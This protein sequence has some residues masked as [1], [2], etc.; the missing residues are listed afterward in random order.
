VTTDPPGSMMVVNDIVVVY[1]WPFEVAL[2]E[3]GRLVKGFYEGKKKKNE[4]K[5]KRKERGGHNNNPSGSKDKKKTFEVQKSN[6]GALQCEMYEA[7]IRTSL[8]Q[9]VL[10]QAKAIPIPPAR[11]PSN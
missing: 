2:D 4:K 10:P 8:V 7:T 9:H 3:R 1:T 6:T 11:H 5:K